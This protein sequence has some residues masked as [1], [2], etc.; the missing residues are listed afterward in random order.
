MLP[1]RKHSVFIVVK[2][3]HSPIYFFVQF[4]AILRLFFLLFIY[5]FGKLVFGNFSNN[6]KKALSCEMLQTPGVT[7]EGVG[8]IEV[9]VT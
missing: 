7:M 5:K 6:H 9:A 4:L 2:S 1:S 3:C 8:T